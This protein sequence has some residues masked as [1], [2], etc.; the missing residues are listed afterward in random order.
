MQSISNDESEAFHIRILWSGPEVQFGYEWH[1]NYFVLL[2][3]TTLDTDNSMEEQNYS[4]FTTVEAV[5]LFKV[6]HN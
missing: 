6:H 3:Y 2:F 5:S 4:L 1:P